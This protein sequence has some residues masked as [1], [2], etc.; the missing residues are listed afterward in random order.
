[1]LL[2]RSLTLG[3][4]GACLYFL[5]SLGKEPPEP[6][7][8]PQRPGLSIV[9]VAHGVT[10]AELPGVLPLAPDE[11]VIAVGEQPVANDL[12]A[13]AAISLLAPPAQGYLDLT[14]RR[15]DQSTRR[16]LVLAH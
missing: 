10:A 6:A 1:M 11:H 15:A 2:F 3:M 9:D 13:G 8:V 4:L 16:V 5:A 14:V 12:E 7:P